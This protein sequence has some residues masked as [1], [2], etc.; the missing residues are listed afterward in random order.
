MESRGIVWRR[1]MS[2]LPEGQRP[3]YYYLNRENAMEN[4]YN[5]HSYK[6]G[7]ICIHVLTVADADY[8]Y[9]LHCPKVEDQLILEARVLARTDLAVLG[10][11][12]A[13]I[14][15]YHAWEH[16]YRYFYPN[17]FTLTPAD[18]LRYKS[19]LTVWSEVIRVISKLLSNLKSKKG[20][21]S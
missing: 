10:L 9:I 3:D 19:L 20:S 13:H 7:N 4:A 12:L 15:L 14:N 8:Q 21:D 2:C 5:N 11:V 1:V 16:T 17:Y 6:L 18:E